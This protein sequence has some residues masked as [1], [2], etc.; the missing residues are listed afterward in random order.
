VPGAP[1]LSPRRAL[2]HA[3]REALERPPCF[4]A[5]SGGRDS[6]A[7]LAVATAVSRTHELPPPIPITLLFS[8][9]SRSEEANWQAHV[10]RHLRLDDWIRLE[11]GDEL[12]LI[13]PVAAPV[14]RVHGVG[15]PANAHFVVPMLR[16]A[17]G[18]TLMTGV[19]GDGLFGG[20]YWS[21]AR[22][23]IARR[24]RPSPRDLLRV[25]LAGSPPPLR[26]AVLRHRPANSPVWLTEVARA[27]AAAAWAHDLAAEPANWRHRVNR[28]ARARSLALV[29]R[30]M[31]LLAR[32]YHVVDA[33]PFS[34][35]HF[36]AALSHHGGAA[37]F[38]DRTAIM[39]ALFGDLLP[40]RVLTRAD[41]AEF[42]EVFWGS[43]ARQ[44][45]EAWSGDGLDPGLINAHKLR[46]NWRTNRP[47]ARSGM[48]LQ[49][50]WLHGNTVAVH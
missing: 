17:R 28:F 36:L 9:A 32:E 33:H 7:V 23:V 18:G 43:T 35:P 42:G 1:G 3:A 44:F 29:L 34:D 10:L 46:A 13:G 26:R 41:K 22:D 50:A 19:D 45:A 37:G 25:G 47:D 2:E 31:H 24:A 5:F 40:D 38:G 20:W 12:D 49:A 6:S 15:Y 39:R 30:R 21:R 16:E 11:P 48:L 8:G 14:L 4:V 27:H